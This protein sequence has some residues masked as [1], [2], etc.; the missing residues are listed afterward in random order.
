MEGPSLPIDIPV[1]IAKTP[2]KNLV[3][4]SGT[5]L[6]SIF[7]CKSPL[8]C[9]IPLPPINGYFA[10]INSTASPRSIKI[11]SPAIIFKGVISAKNE[12]LRCEDFSSSTV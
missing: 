6:N 9:G 4:S 12:F 7:F 3:N 2:P 11:A 5:Q 8:T 1:P 10:S